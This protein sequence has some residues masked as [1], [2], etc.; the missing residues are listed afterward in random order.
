M[1]ILHISSARAFG[2]GERHLSDLVS[3][4]AVHGHEVYVALRSNS[5]LR[6]RLP[7]LF[8]NNLITLPLR[9]ALDIG[10]AVRLSRFMRERRIEIVHAHVARDYPLAAFAV[11]RSVHGAQLVVTRHV[12]FPLGRIHAMTLARR[13]ARVIAVSE[14]V[15]GVL[16]AQKIFAAGKIQVIF[17][18]IDLEKFDLHT[19]GFDRDAY[20]ERLEMRAPLLVGTIGELSRVKGQE[21]FVRAAAIVARRCTSAV[22]FVIV[23]EDSSPTGHTRAHLEK[24]INQ[25]GIADRV[26]LV[27]HRDD[28]AALLASLDVFVSTSRSEAFGLSIVEAM[29]AGVPIVATATEGARET[30]ADGAAGKLVPIGDVDALAEAV[31]NLLEH[32]EERERL[33]AHARG[34]VSARFS[35][36]RMVEATEQVYRDVLKEAVA[37]S[38]EGTTLRK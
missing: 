19:C 11:S 14:A 38:T 30:T 35:L 6:S 2:G 24:L 1:R 20:R 36:E 28:T 16:R 7:A 31:T 34:M 32:V 22:E 23:G 29:A 13:V 12:L 4:L 25:L 27:G 26:R 18:G 8:A 15:A 3:A 21:D 10:S 17:N 37:G 5:P 33:S 9:N